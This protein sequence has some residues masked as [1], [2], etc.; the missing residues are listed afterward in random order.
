LHQIPA[1]RNL[2]PCYPD[3][4]YGTG[5]NGIMEPPPIPARGLISIAAEAVMSY[6]GT[7]L[8]FVYDISIMSCR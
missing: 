4:R 2:N 8:I 3:L 1:I 6:H 5:S 7:F